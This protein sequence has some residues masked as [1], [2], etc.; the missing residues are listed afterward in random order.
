MNLEKIVWPVFRLS[1]RKPF[2]DS[3]V[4][5]YA[6]EYT[7]LDTHLHTGTLRIVDDRNIEKPTLSRRRLELLAQEVKLFPIYKAIY[8]LSDLLKLAKAT[9][10]FIDSA[11]TLF[12]YEKTKRAKLIVRK[13]TK[14]LPTEGLG[15]VIELEGIPQRFKTTFKPDADAE[16]GAVLQNGL[17]YILYGIYNEKP[18]ES[19]RLI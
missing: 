3:G 19:W 15:S 5:Y 10:W 4:V 11:G 18:R 8:F 7:D 1:E 9:T 6:T 12:Q 14:V 17:S 16:Y 13:I 2:I